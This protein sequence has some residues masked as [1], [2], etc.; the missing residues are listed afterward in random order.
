M[1]CLLQ[2]VL[3]GQAV[4][5]GAEHAHVVG[6]RAVHAALVQLGAAEVV[7]A[8]DHDGHL[9]PAA[10]DVGDLARRCSGRRPGRRRARRR[11]RRPRPRA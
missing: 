8:A 10:H 4:H 9:G 5:D 11:R 2:E 7:A 3:Q 6:A 1:P